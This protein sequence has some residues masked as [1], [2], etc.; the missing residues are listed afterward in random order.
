M[1][2]IPLDYSLDFYGAP[3]LE[4]SAWALLGLGGTAAL[5]LWSKARRQ[6]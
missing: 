6:R 5:V 3:V 2:S 4:P 1:N